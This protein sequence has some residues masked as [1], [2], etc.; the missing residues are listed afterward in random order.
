VKLLFIFRLVLV[1][2]LILSV[3]ITSC[4][5]DAKCDCAADTIAIAKI[6]QPNESSGKDAIIENITPDQNF[7]NTSHFT[8]FSWTNGGLFNTAR[9]LIEFDLSGIPSQTQIKKAELC[10]YWISR[11]NLTEHTG[12]NAFT[13]YRITQEW[14]ENAVTWNNQPPVAE[15]NKVAVSK[16]Q[17][18]DQSYTGIDVTGLVQGIIENPAENYGFMLKLNEEFPYR[19]VILASSDH[20]DAGRRPKLTVYY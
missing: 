11:E 5:K 16:S 18:S 10:L 15:D 3:P 19:L 2:L 17:T 6:F 12:D 20:T 9:A 14:D 13:I 8:V 4:L 7:G 1:V